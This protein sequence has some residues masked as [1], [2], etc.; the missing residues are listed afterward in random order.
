MDTSVSVNLLENNLYV[1]DN[2]LRFDVC[3]S[4][5][6]ID[7]TAH[8]IPL[9]DVGMSSMTQKCALSNHSTCHTEPTIHF[10]LITLANL[11]DASNA[12]GKQKLMTIGILGYF[13][14]EK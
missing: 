2:F 3:Y 8:L 13:P 12:N 11:W 6:L 5:K 4:G 10:F 7:I 9:R 1:L 14:L